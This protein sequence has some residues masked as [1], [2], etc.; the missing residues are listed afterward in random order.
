[1]RRWILAI[2]IAVSLLAPLPATAAA[3]PTT[4]P[5]DPVDSV[6]M[7][8]A[9][10]A[11]LATEIDCIRLATRDARP[12]DPT[13]R[14]VDVEV[15][16]CVAAGFYAGDVLERVRDVLAPPGFFAARNFTF[17]EPLR[18]SAI[19]AAVQ[20]VPGVAHVDAIFVRVHG[21]GDWRPF[22]E[23]AI[24]TDPDEIIR[25]QDD[26]DH[27]TLGLLRVRAAGVM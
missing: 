1:M 4:D 27:S 10:R 20:G 24:A 9:Q 22:E 11:E 16:V 14:D 23:S 13:Y 8:D 5:V 19:E 26:P 2:V 25:L 15:L 6:A 12:V 17:G 18:R 21:I 7:T 3:D